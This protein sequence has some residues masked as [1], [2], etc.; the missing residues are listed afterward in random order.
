MD[1]MLP[2]RHV[3]RPQP[4]HWNTKR[5]EGQHG[6]TLILFKQQIIYCLKT[7]PVP[8]A[9]IIQMFYLL[10]QVEVH[11]KLTLLGMI[12]HGTQATTQDVVLLMM[13]MASSLPLNAVLVAVEIVMLN[14]LTLTLKIAL[15]IQDLMIALGTQPTSQDVR[16]ALM[17]EAASS[18]ALSAVL[19]AVEDLEVLL[20]N[21]KELG[22]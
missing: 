9:M 7:Q 13:E 20:S 21:S 16:V 6:S 3:Q 15:Q 5:L 4:I 12:A 10:L 18:L 1:Q 14:A 11:L 8:H 19:V 2:G 17:M 22:T